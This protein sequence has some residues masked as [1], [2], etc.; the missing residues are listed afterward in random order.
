VGVTNDDTNRG[1]KSSSFVIL[2]IVVIVWVDFANCCCVDSSRSQ[3]E[4]CF[5]FFFGL[6]V[7]TNGRGADARSYPIKVLW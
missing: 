7:K 3:I 6:G 2:D 5:L 4:E 1:Q